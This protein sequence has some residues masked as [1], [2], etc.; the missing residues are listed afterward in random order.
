MSSQRVLHPRFGVADS[1]TLTESLATLRP[2]VLAGARAVALQC[3]TGTWTHADA[4]P[5][6]GDGAYASALARRG[7]CSTRIEEII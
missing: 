5:F 1:R 7:V 6:G 3:G 4:R 2:H